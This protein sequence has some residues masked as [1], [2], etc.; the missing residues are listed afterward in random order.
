MEASSLDLVTRYVANGY[1]IGLSVEAGEIVKHPAVRVLPLVGFPPIEIAAFWNGDM[2]PVVREV[3]TA[4][5][6]YATATWPEWSACAR[7]PW[8]PRARR[9]HQASPAQAKVVPVGK[10]SPKRSASTASNSA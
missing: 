5:H 10:R 4:M 7:L 9:R 8:E 2:R 1:G 3:V 6:H